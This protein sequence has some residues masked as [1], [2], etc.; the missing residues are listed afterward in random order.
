LAIVLLNAVLVQLNPEII[1]AENA[2]LQ[3]KIMILLKNKIYCG[4]NFILLMAALLS[5]AGGLVQCLGKALIQMGTN[6]PKHKHEKRLNADKPYLV[7]TR[8]ASRSC[9]ADK[10]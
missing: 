10:A 6:N 9:R 7:P 4:D 1:L 3:L 5:N 8:L 2:I